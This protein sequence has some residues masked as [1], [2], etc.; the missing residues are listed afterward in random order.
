MSNQIIDK[1]STGSDLFIAMD[2]GNLH[3]FVSYTLKPLF[4]KLFGEKVMV[5]N[6]F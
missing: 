5:D 6:P 1:M 3:I 4:I 2:K